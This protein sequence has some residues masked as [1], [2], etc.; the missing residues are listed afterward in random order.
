MTRIALITGGNRGIGRSTALQL[1]RDG[2]DV[3]VTYRS[4]AEEAEQVAAEIE[5]LGRKAAALQPDGGSI[6]NISTG[7][8]RFYTPDRAVYAAAKGAVDVLTRF[9]AQELGDRGITVNTIAPGA[10]AT[11]FSGGLVRDTPAVQQ[12]IAANTALGRYA[13]DERRR[14]RASSGHR[15]AVA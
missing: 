7:Q 9:L 5:A 2:V 8:T 15:R 6:V 12:A 4:H 1:T 10:V 11:D 3:I 13:R 14:P